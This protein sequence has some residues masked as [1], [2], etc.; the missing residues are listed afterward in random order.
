MARTFWAALGA[1]A[2]VTL[3]GQ[4]NAA[5]VQATLGGD[6]DDLRPNYISWQAMLVY[7]TS[8]GDLTVTPT[9]E[10][11]TWNS[12]MASPSPL[13]DFSG[14]IFG[15][16]GTTFDFTSAT[17][18]TITRDAG[19]YLFE[20]SGTDFTARIGFGYLQS[21]PQPLDPGNTDFSLDTDYH[22]I[23]HYAYG[24]LFANGHGRPGYS[25]LL[26]VTKLADSPAGVP[27]PATWAM[28]LCGFFGLGAV[29]RG[30]R[31]P[32]PAPPA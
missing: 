22:H 17:S 21:S 10:V 3:A 27:E 13:I 9:S 18:F 25:Y 28:M 23:D 11:L 24:D 5:I 14:Q 16:Q 7:D 31:R 26:T 20:L 4:A 2:L 15:T 32:S 29:L 1:A 19:H 6:Y 30:R 8:L 12:G